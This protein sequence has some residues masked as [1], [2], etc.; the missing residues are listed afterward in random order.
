MFII[1][2]IIKPPE[3]L[4][5]RRRTIKEINSSAP[6]VHRTSGGLPFYT[7]RICE[8]KGAVN[9]DAV[10]RKCSRYA[11]KI[12]VP[13][14]VYIPDTCNLLRFVPK[15]FGS[16]LV[17]NTAIN[18]LKSAAISPQSLALTLSDRSGIL[19]GR[20]HEL[21]E[22]SSVIK[23]ITLHPER[24]ASACCKAYE[25]YGAS[26][27]LRS[28]HEQTAKPELII[29]ADGCFSPLMHKSAVIAGK[30]F[31]AGALK[32]ICSGMDL[33]KEH[34]ALLPDGIQAYDFAGA[35]TELCFCRDYINS[36][37]TQAEIQGEYSACE[38]AAQAL[39]RYTADT[40]FT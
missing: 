37:F 31:S 2:D 6:E 4:R 13:R 27:I 10:N 14:T 38:S 16:T 25:E 8:D 26:V 11:S 22:Y 9:W 36:S 5:R 34:A 30:S 21:L 39:R 35:L 23:I 12:I 1:L 17:F 32:I 20:L 24:Y 15:H 19:N 7:A 3:K 40:S 33:N 29:A 28:S 18:L